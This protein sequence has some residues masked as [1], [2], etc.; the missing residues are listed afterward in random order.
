MV[1][2]HNTTGNKAQVVTFAKAKPTVSLAMSASTIKKGKSVTVTVRV[3][4]NADKPTGTV[5]VTRL[6]GSIAGGTVKTVTL[7]N[8]AGS[9]VYTPKVAGTF[10]YQ[11]TYSGDAVYGSAT[12][13]IATLKI[14]T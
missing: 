3:T 7:V 8:G 9:F 6:P 11:A 13:P 4:G 1:H 10:R 12:S 2:F 14:T 5:T